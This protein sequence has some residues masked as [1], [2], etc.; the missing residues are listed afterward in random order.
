VRLT[1][2]CDADEEHVVLRALAAAGIGPPDT[3]A[4]MERLGFYVCVEDLEDEL[5]R[6]IGAARVESLIDSQGDLGSVR[7]LQRQPKWRGQ[8][9]TAQLR[10]FFGSGSRRKLRYARLLAGAVA[11]DRLPRPVAGRTRAGR[12]GRRLGLVS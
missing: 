2:L 7:S 12:A 11:L 8:P 9:T 5:I 1:G 10:R 6:S 3:R 4:D